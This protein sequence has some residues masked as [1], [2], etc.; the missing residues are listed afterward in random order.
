MPIYKIITFTE[1]ELVACLNGA[2]LLIEC[3]CNDSRTAEM[4]ED[5]LNGMTLQQVGDKF[6]LSKESIRLVLKDSKALRL[7]RKRKNRMKE[8]SLNEKHLQREAKI[9]RGIE[10]YQQ[11]MDLKELASEIGLNYTAVL[12]E[13]RKRGFNTRNQV[14]TRKP[15]PRVTKNFERVLKRLKR[16][17]NLGAICK[18][19]KIPY[20]KMLLLLNKSGFTCKG[21]ELKM[22]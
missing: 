10:L 2:N 9:L 17:D 19:W 13:L 4:M 5:Y 15:D 1:D 20:Q 21:Q 11:G 14:G 18:E 8:Q 7:K 22:E 12:K 16:G 3:S 6:G